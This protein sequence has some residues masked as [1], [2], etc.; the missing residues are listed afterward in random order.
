MTKMM[1]WPMMT[2]Q[3]GRLEKKMARRKTMKMPIS[4]HH[5]KSWPKW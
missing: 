1:S 5:M 4:G 3:I 2:N